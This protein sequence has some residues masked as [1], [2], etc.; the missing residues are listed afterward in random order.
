[1]STHVFRGIEIEIPGIYNEGHRL[2]AEEANAL[3]RYRAELIMNRL[4]SAMKDVSDEELTKD[5]VEHKLAELIK[6][7]TW[8]PSRGG[9]P[10][11]REARAIAFDL[12]KKEKAK[13]VAEE[14]ARRGYDLSDRAQV[15][16]GIKAL[17]PDT[18]QRIMKLAQEKVNGLI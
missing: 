17:K 2:S 6:T 18:Y 14:L 7:F 9:D 13:P 15:L 5:A 4:R 8:N 16:E 1:M 11:L 3:N 12:I 10:V